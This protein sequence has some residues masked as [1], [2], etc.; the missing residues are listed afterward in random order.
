MNR[1][2]VNALKS[3]GLVS[4]GDDPEAQVTFW[5]SADFDKREFDREQRDR[6]AASGVAL[7]DGSFP[8]VNKQDLANAIQAFGR[9]G[10]KTAARK[11]IIKRARALGATEMLPDGWDMTKMSTDAESAKTLQGDGMP[12]VDLSAIEDADLRKSIEETY[13]G[14]QTRIA[15]LQSQIDELNPPDPVEKADPEIQ[16]LVKAQEERLA[17]A[18][19][20]LAK[21]RSERR[22]TEYIGKAKPLEMLLGKADEMGPVLAELAEAAPDAYEKLE[23]ALV[24]AS[25]RDELAKLFAKMGTEGEGEA[26][27]IGRRDAFVKSYL[28]DNP[29][30][31]EVEARAEFWKQNPDAKQDLRS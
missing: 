18:E 10:N 5:K 15:E 25:Q 26:D 6:L 30:K 13:D 20:A 2:F 3:V 19:E 31:S 4:S 12:E 17:K 16:E 29:G 7:P 1:L 21:E 23:G 27:P 8:I 11:H 22:R 28:A 9:A 24:A 14:Q